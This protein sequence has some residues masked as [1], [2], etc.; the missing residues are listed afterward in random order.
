MACERIVTHAIARVMPPAWSRVLRALFVVYVTATAIHIGW[1]LMHEPFF[2]DA[3]NVAWDTHAKPITVG[4]F[5]DYWWHEYTHS[6]PRLGQVFAYLG[7]KLE[8]FS[9]VAAPLGSGH[10]VSFAIRPL[11]RMET[12]GTFALAL[13]AIAHWNR[14]AAPAPADPARRPVSTD[15][16]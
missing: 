16:R 5:F 13:N 14:L 11:W 8:Y 7:Y 6:N 15:G 1:V 4:N 10:I 2:F 3:W 9:V 12:Q